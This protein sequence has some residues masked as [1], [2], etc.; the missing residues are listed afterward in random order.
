MSEHMY[1]LVLKALK[2]V[3]QNAS[4]MVINADEVTTIDNTTSCGV[5]VYV[6]KYWTRVPHFWVCDDSGCDHFAHVIMN[7]FFNER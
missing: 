3:V 6:V 1:L 2:S 5:D 4:V 7:A